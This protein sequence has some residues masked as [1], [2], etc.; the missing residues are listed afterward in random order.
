MRLDVDAVV[1]PDGW[2]VRAQLLRRVSARTIQAWL[3]AGKLRRLRPGV[4]ATPEAAKRWPV[5]VAAALHGREAVASHGTALALWNMVTPPPGLVHVT[6]DVRRSVRGSLGLVLHRAQ[7]PYSDRRRVDGLPVTP[8]ERAVVDA[9][10]RPV[11]AQPRGRPSGRHHRRP[12]SFLLR[13]GPGVRAG[14]EFAAARPCAAGGTR[15]VARRWLPERAG[16]LGLPPRPA[17]TRDAAVHAA[18]ADRGPR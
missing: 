5:R 18:A 6:V 9:W 13:R 2:V 4:Y 12:A 1:G 7:D 16:N 17:R 15:P 11:K 3:A 8:V 14:E 10:G